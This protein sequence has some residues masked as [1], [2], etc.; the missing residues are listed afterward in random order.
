MV[1][2]A[3]PHI[4]AFAVRNADR[5]VK[6]DGLVRRS[7]REIGRRGELVDDLQGRPQVPLPVGIGDVAAQFE[8]RRGGHRRGG[9][10]LV[11]R[12]RVEVP[13]G[14]PAAAESRR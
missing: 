10:V 13:V 2:G 4:D 8:E 3:E 6:Q 5:A 9:R 11:Q 7:F 14:H 1:A 12:G